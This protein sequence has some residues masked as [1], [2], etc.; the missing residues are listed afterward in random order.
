LE[1]FEKR[2]FRAMK[3]PQ[4]APRDFPQNLR[5]YIKN[6][7]FEYRPEVTD[8]LI[9]LLSET[10]NRERG[11]N[12]S[13]DAL[14]DLLLLLAYGM[15]AE[16]RKRG[17]LSEDELKEIAGKHASDVDLQQLAEELRTQDARFSEKA[18]LRKLK[19]FIKATRPV[20]FWGYLLDSLQK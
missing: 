12:L 6:G 11:L 10:V 14:F 17:H 18:V 15:Y 3:K 20:G 7:T 9:A 8:E 2:A 16:S 13:D 1:Q 5:D 19:Q 4:I